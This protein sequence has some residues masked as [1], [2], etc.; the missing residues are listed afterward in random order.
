[1]NILLLGANGQLGRSFIEHGG[2]A[3]RGKL[4]AATRDGRR[5][6]GNPAEVADLS[7]PDTLPSLLDRLQPRLIVNT[8]AYTAVDRAE[9]EEAQ[10]T[11]IN[12]DAVGV[13]AKWTANNDALVIHYSTDYVFSGNATAPYP[14]SAPAAPLGAYGRSK[15]AGEI[16]LRESGAHHLLLRTAWVYS[17]HGQ[18]FLRTML[19]LAGEREEIRIVADQHGSPTDTT[20]IVQ[21]TLAALDTW[22]EADPMRRDQ[23]N[24]VHHLVASGS[25]TWH[26]FAEVIMQ[27]AKT[28]GLL[29]RVPKLTPI[30]TA[31]F[32]TP[33]RRPAWSVLDNTGFQQQFSYPMPDW[34]QG[35]RHIIKALVL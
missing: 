11:R 18:N 5:F 13:L 7:Q 17:S 30:T 21:A 27:E 32:P 1:M 24:G 28:L 3:T 19:R 31:E 20:L 15:L 23:L 16:S 33:A 26:G 6:D 12:G 2:L 34:R 8:A 9:S 4:F 14:I 10:A 35:L 22:L 25:T 29:T